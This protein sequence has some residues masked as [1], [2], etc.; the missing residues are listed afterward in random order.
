MR[1]VT[2]LLIAQMVVL[3]GHALAQT[4]PPP[5]TIAPV[6]VKG[7][8]TCPVTFDGHVS[9][10]EYGDATALTFAN[11][12]GMVD[13]WAKCFDGF[14]YFAFQIPDRSPFQGDD[15]VVML[16]TANG[17]AAAPDKND[18]RAYVRRKM[19][20]S[21]QYQGDGKKW[22][23]YYG[24]W[25]YRAMPYAIGWEVEVRIPLKALGV[26]PEQAGRAWS[27]LP[28]LGQRAA[29]DVELAGGI[30]REQAQYLGH[31]STPTG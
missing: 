7:A 18:V 20:N 15:I 5:G 16:D 17:R 2:F 13:V 30:G 4:A 21:R 25:E 12:H 10:F 23:D 29:E 9:K 24:E 19:E 1:L 31:D 14:L 27:G 11:G 22:V 28:H 6:V 8:S 26:G 3:T